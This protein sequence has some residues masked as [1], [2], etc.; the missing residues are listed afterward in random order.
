MTDKQLLDIFLKRAEASGKHYNPALKNPSI[1]ITQQYG[2]KLYFSIKFDGSTSPFWLN[3]SKDGITMV[4]SLPEQLPNRLMDWKRE[5]IRTIMNF[6]INYVEFDLEKSPKEIVHIFFSS[7]ISAL[8]TP[9]M[10]VGLFAYNNTN[11]IFE[12]NET[13]EEISI[14]ADLMSFDQDNVGF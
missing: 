11:Y 6:H 9:G 10:S 5:I 13:Y 12:A 3:F 8:N 1:V 7:L 4:F 14:E 2:K